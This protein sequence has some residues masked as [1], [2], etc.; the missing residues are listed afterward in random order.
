MSGPRAVLASF[1]AIARAWEPKTI[2]VYQAAPG[3][4]HICVGDTQFG[5]D[6][7]GTVVL[8][9]VL[10]R[11]LEL[12]RVSRHATAKAFRVTDTG[13]IEIETYAP[14]VPADAAPPAPPTPP[15]PPAPPAPAGDPAG[16]TPPDGPDAP[17]PE[18]PAGDLEAGAP[19]A[20]EDPLTPDGD[21]AAD[22]STAA[23]APPAPP[24]PAPAA[25][26]AKGAK[27]PGRG[28]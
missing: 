20:T 6:P 3:T 1:A 10:G 18:T 5:V 22:A 25:S 14:P 12:R 16:A 11:Q 23:P 4:A 8:P 7:D 26:P 9:D 24:A 19:A 27:A 17:A 13:E 21:A 15:A 28:R 2:S